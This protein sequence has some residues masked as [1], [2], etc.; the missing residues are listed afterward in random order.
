M[1]ELGALRAE[2]VAR[3]AMRLATAGLVHGSG[4]IESRARR[5]ARRYRDAKECQGIPRQQAGESETG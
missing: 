4:T 1:D 5:L 3:A 2:A